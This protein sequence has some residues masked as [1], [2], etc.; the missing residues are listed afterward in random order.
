MDKLFACNLAVFPHS[1]CPPRGGNPTTIFLGDLD[2]TQMQYLAKQT[3]HECGFVLCSPVP[4]NGDCHLTMRYWVPNHEME[5]CGHATIGAIWLL[6]ELGRL[7]MTT[8]NIRVST[9]SG[10]VDARVLRIASDSHVRILVSQPRGQVDD[11]SDTY[12][13]QINS[14][15]GISLDDFM[16]GHR[17]HNA[18]TSRTKTLVPVWGV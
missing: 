8:G 15:L 7:P 6:N 16:P 2:E 10:V 11:L 14:C 1:I 17:V 5:M 4:E 13:S 18:R 3:T 9:K 12:V